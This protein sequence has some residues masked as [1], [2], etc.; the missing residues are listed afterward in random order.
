MKI[1]IKKLPVYYNWWQ[2]RGFETTTPKRLV[3]Q[4]RGLNSC[5]KEKEGYLSNSKNRNF[6]N[7]K[8]T[9]E[10][11]YK[12][13]GRHWGICPTLTERRSSGDASKTGGC[14]G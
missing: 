9:K 11:H 13:P 14:C 6:S 4:A 8:H 12:Q 3:T 1:Y 5:K 10:W 7:K 2:L